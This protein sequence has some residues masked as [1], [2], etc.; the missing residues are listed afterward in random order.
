MAGRFVRSSKYRHVFGTASKPDQQFTSIR[1]INDGATDG[2]ICAVNPKFV[3]VA[4]KP[5]GGGAFL[6]LKHDEAGRIDNE[7]P[8]VRGHKG[9][10]LDLAWDPFDDNVIASGDEHSIVCVW[11]IPD[12]GLTESI[13]EPRV[14]LDCHQKKIV[15]ILWHPT[16]RNILLTSA[17]DCKV[18]IWN[19]ETVEGFLE[20][21]TPD[22]PY[23]VDWD[24][25]G[26]R[27]VVACKDKKIRVYDSH[28]GTKLSEWNGHE[29]TKPQMV[30]F[31]KQGV[32]TTGFS[33]MSTREYALWNEKTGEQLA[34]E[35]LDSSNGVNQII[36]DRDTG[37]FYF[38][39]KGDSVIR[40]YE[41][42]GEDPFL[43]YLSTYQA[44]PQTAVGIM[45][46][47]GCNVN[48]CEVMR[49]YRIEKADKGNTS[50][51][52][53][54][55]TAM[56]VPRKSETFQED[57]F[58][59]TPGDEPS[60]TAEEFQS[61]KNKDPIL[62]SLKSGYKPKEKSV[63]AGGIM[64]KVDGGSQ[65]GSKMQSKGLSGDKSGSGAGQSTATGAASTEL[66]ALKDEVNSLKATV[67]SQQAKI[68]A[69]EGKLEELAGKVN[70]TE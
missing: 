69:L 29:G 60:M 44:K 68:E 17:W 38:A 15:K 70:Q 46:K 62:M 22:V 66:S 63:R 10:V 58:P 26:S 65:L 47:R 6:V 49:F 11:E 16:A 23:S 2:H 7:H 19:L 67:E 34:Q 61:G 1:G 43:F 64:K 41:M 14:T 59:D 50:Q 27:I 28:E 37:M 31:T 18:I 36:Y 32:L 53:I 25:N 33:K 13:T 48:A 42:T 9:K 20:I 21:E 12:S 5:S 39:A 4:T 8:Q 54:I 51:F 52:V 35:D 56:T 57:I 45:P 30:A 40:Y 55:P 24:Y 3:A